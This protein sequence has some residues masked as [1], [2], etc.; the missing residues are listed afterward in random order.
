MQSTFHINSMDFRKIDK[1][2]KKFDMKLLVFDTAYTFDL[3]KKRGI[4]EIITS[5]NLKGFFTKV[6]NANFSSKLLNLRDK[7]LKKETKIKLNENCY[8]IESNFCF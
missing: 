4:E 6:V 5:R 1:F 7:N 8:I 2:F 3:I